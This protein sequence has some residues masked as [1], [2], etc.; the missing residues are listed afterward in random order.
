MSFPPGDSCLSSDRCVLSSWGPRMGSC[1][2]S[3]RSILYS[4]G[5]RMNSCLSSDASFP[6]WA[7]FTFSSAPPPSCNPSPPPLRAS[8]LSLKFLRPRAHILPRGNGESTYHCP[9]PKWQ[10]P[11]S[12]Q[13]HITQSV[14]IEQRAWVVPLTGQQ[15]AAEGAG[16]CSI[17][18]TVLASVTLAS[19]VLFD[20]CAATATFIF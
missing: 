12:L 14:F 8:L 2:S 4:W 16:N 9:R 17:L 20:L 10:P 15:S 18:P 11:D 5:P 19:V 13:F 3:E 6:P 7:P 1:L